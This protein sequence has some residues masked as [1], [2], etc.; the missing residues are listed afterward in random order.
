[1]PTS[2]QEI[3]GFREYM[4]AV[5]AAL[6]ESPAQANTLIDGLEPKRRTFGDVEQNLI[7]GTRRLNS[8]RA[9]LITARTE[10]MQALG[11]RE[12]SAHSCTFI[13]EGGG[14]ACL[15]RDFL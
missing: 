12:S 4:L 10:L 8:V 6:G 7:P 5:Q 1:M 14:R 15:G 3:Q 11:S 2:I 9:E 13:T